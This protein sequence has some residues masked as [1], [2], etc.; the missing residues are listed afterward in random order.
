MK[1]QYFKST[2][3]THR[4]NENQKVWISLNC[5]N[6]M[7]IWYKWRSKGRSVRGIIDKFDKAVGEIK[8]IDVDDD[9]AK[10]VYGWFGSY[11]EV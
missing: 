8:T 3:R 5:A 2:R 6:H 7:Y 9:F 1:V 11:I 4:F 10:R